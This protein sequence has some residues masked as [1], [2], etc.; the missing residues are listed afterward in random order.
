[1]SDIRDVLKDAQEDICRRAYADGDLP[2]DLTCR[3]IRRAI[4]EIDRLRGALERIAEEEDRGRHDGF[5]EPG[6]RHDEYQAWII[7][8]TALKGNAV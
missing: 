2:E 6:P 3:D 4:A 5:P 7:A 8:R 1:M